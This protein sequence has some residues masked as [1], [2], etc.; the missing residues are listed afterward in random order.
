MSLTG[1][2]VTSTF[3]DSFIDNLVNAVDDDASNYTVDFANN[4]PDAAVN[5]LSGDL[6]ITLLRIH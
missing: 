1:L 6:M 2:S 5:I 3:V 4:P